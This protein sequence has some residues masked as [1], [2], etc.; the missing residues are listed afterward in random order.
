MQ[1]Q[2]VQVAVMI[3]VVERLSHWALGK[4]AV[5]RR[6]ESYCTVLIRLSI[7]FIMI[8]DPTSHE[9]NLEP[10]RACVRWPRTQGTR[11]MDPRSSASRILP[12]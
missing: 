5:V 8:I 4:V 12:W 7:L 9:H 2:C 3:E 1:F 6:W 10:G 11:H